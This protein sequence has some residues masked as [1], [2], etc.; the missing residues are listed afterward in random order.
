MRLMQVRCAALAL[1]ALF[2]Q[3]W[4]F[5]QTAIA[6][7]RILLCGGQQVREMEIQ[8]QGNSAR[9]ALVWHWRPEESSIL[10]NNVLPR[11]S[12]VD[13]CKSSPDGKEILVSSSDGAVAIVNHAT[14]EVLF[15][16]EVPNAHSIAALPQGLV[17]AAASTHA[18]GNRLILFERAHSNAPIYSLPLE[19]AH[20]VVW[21]E[22]RKVLWALGD[23]ELLRLTLKD[24][25]L[26]VEK[27]YALE[28]AGGHDLVPAKDWRSLYVTASNGPLVFDIATETFSPYQ[29][30]AGLKN[31]KSVSFNPESG[32][33]AYTM[34]D[35]RVWWTYTVRFHNPDFSIPIESET[36][37][38]RWSATSH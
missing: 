21:D 28:R 27:R 9:F 31:V 5:S 26:V 10:P 32:Q 30:L 33:L 2:A 38:V 29:T 13:D 14:S 7:D 18:D 16:A 36:Y 8:R 19:G 24:K 35:P 25:T 1:G 20:G 17:V 3:V 6:A 22:Q 34:A 11:Y 37:K 23:K 4:M 12:N 15:Y